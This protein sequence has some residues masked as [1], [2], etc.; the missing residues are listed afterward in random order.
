MIRRERVERTYGLEPRDRPPF[1]PAI[2]EHKAFL[3]GCSPS[4]LCRSQ[5]LLEA[6]LEREREL[7]DPDMLVLGVD[8][9]NV[10]AEA[11][12]CPVAYFEDRNDVPAVITPICRHRAD[13]PRLRR[14]DP[15][16]DG[17]MPLLL[18][19]A[20]ALA[21]RYGRERVIRGAVSGP[22]SIAAALVGPEHFL[23]ALLDSPAFARATLAFAAEVSCAFGLAF[24]R[25]G[26]EPIVFDSRAAPP[27]LS[28]RL[29]REFVLPLY[30]DRIFPA[31]KAAGGRLLPLIIGGNTTPILDALLASGATQLLCDAGADLEAFLDGC[32]RARLAFRASVDARLV[33]R[34]PPSAIRAAAEQ[35]LARAG[36]YPGLLLGCGVVAYD[37]PPAHVLA[38]REAL[39]GFSS[40][41]L[42]AR[43]PDSPGRSA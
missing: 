35:I 15:E 18:K 20:A 1:V 14:P 22:F 40:G 11:A 19:T 8:V 13:L 9:Y 26:V 16:R 30:R 23:M 34:G 5:E 7:Y 2:Y 38:I 29:F 28:P 27:L 24:L 33:H 37:T 21:A 39:E 6:A 41:E 32:G 4:Q 36:H 10:E 42:T 3:V 31:W 12:G 25:R 43:R 17:R